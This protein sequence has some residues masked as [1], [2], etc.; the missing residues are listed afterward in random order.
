MNPKNS[1]RY[2]EYKTLQILELE[3]FKALRIPTSA[4]GK[5]PLPDI[6]AVKDGIIYAI[7]VKSTFQDYVYVD[8]FQINK[9]FEFCEIFNFCNC[10]EV[11]IVHYKKYKSVKMYTLSQDARGKEKIKFVYRANS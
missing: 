9:L 5:Q 10:K 2:Y 4:T 11:V 1:G 3:G 7:E 8:N 6:I